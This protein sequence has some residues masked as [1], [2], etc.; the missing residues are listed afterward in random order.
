M[1]QAVHTFGVVL[2]PA[3]VIFVPAG[4]VAK[5]VQ[6]AALAALE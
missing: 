3:S 4:Q 6:V 2:L 5:G 1:A